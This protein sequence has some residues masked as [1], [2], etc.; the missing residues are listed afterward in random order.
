[1]GRLPKII[2]DTLQS[3]RVT[4]E[5]AKLCGGYPIETDRAIRTDGDFSRFRRNF[6]CAAAVIKDGKAIRRY[7]PPFSIPAELPAAGKKYPGVGFD[8]KKS[9]AG[10]GEVIRPPVF[11]IGPSSKTA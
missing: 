8:S 6:Y 2:P 10:D 4:R 9:F 7:Q 5:D 1:M 11:T 3:L